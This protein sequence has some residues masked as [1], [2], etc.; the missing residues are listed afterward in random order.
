MPLVT[1][2]DGATQT[3]TEEA[4]DPSQ[5]QEATT[6]EHRD[7]PT[8]RFH[9]RPKTAPKSPLKEPP[10][11]NVARKRMQS[12]TSPLSEMSKAKI[13]KSQPTL[14]SQRRQ[15]GDYS[16]E[17]ESRREKVRKAP[18]T[19]VAY[20]VRS[21]ERVTHVPEFSSDILNKYPI[22]PRFLHAAAPPPPIVEM[23]RWGERDEERRPPEHTGTLT[24]PSIKP[25]A[26]P[27]RVDART[28]PT[29]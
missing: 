23:R 22:P 12:T 28:K 29:K 6:I 4:E 19:D 25:K 15:S 16:A 14:Q 9:S 20:R 10:T 17:E 7:K 2:C 24:S 13:P 8:Y 26:L 18:S 21:L 11:S 5:K 3:S 1:K 27:P